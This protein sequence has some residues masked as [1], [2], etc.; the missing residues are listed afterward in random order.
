M[1]TSYDWVFLLSNITMLNFDD[2]KV[3][4]FN[5]FTW[6]CEMR[7]NLA[8]E[9]SIAIVLLSINVDLESIKLRVIDIA[10]IDSLISCKSWFDD[11]IFL[12]IVSSSMTEVFTAVR[13]FLNIFLFNNHCFHIYNKNSAS[14]ALLVIYSLF[15]MLYWLC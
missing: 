2:L 8:A 13:C 4:R 7:F 11:F 3:F 9:F 14:N 10:V 15:W 6:S 1:W 12:L 5:Y